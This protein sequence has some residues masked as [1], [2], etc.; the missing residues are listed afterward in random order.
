LAIQGGRISTDDILDS[1]ITTAKIADDAVE[2]EKIGANEVLTAAILDANVTNAKL[3]TDISAAKLTAGTV[4]DARFPATLP[5]ANGSGLTNLAA[6][7]L[8]TGTVGTARLGT[9]TANSTTFL[10]GDSTFAAP[11]STSTIVPYNPII[12][13]DFLIWQRGV[14]IT[15]ATTATTNGDD[16]YVADR[17]VLLSDGDDIVDVKRSTDAPNGGS[18]NSCFLEIETANK[19]FGIVQIIEQINCHDM[20]GETVS[21]TFK[22]R[23]NATTNLDDV[24]AAIVSWTG[25]VD[26]P[27]SDIVSAW[28][29]EGTNPTLA[30]SWTYENT[31]AD[32]NVTTSWAEYKIE[33]IDID[34]SG[35]VN[36]AVF[37]WSN[38]TTTSVSEQF[39]ITDVQLNKGATAGDF[40][41]KSFNTVENE[42]LRYY[43]T[44]MTWGTTGQYQG[45]LPVMGIAGATFNAATNNLPGRSIR[46]RKRVTPTYTIYHQDGTAGAVYTIHTGAKITGVVAQ[47]LNDF[48]WLFTMKSSA[49]ATGIGYYYAYIAEAEL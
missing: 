30:T 8:T 36:I 26:A 15:S 28:E 4:P 41:R 10:R 5:A 29:A 49:F 31:P 42:C 48:G 34:Q 18:K 13:G 25:T 17:W 16:K 43:E 20:L 46:N 23:V 3:G 44:S 37:I 6:N 19:K 9:G 32:L 40:E 39:Y 38:V 22:A 21:L 1:A 35:A 24:R 27:T 14:T 12:N 7:Q 47:H 2:S 45:Q 33:N 11:A